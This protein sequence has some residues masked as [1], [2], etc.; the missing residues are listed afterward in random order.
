M[1]VIKKKYKDISYF[2]L[3]ECVRTDGKTEQRTLEKFKNELPEKYKKY[4]LPNVD[5][6]NLDYLNTIYHG[7]SFELMEQFKKQGLKVNLIL[8]DPPYNIAQ[9]S[10][11]T[12]QGNDIVSNHKAWGNEYEDNKPDAEAKEWLKRL[13]NYCFDILDDEGSCVI[14]FDRAKPHL[15]EEFHKLF[16]YRNSI[17][18]IKSNPIPHIRKTNYRSTF[19]QCFWFTKSDNYFL[20]FVSQ[21]DM[22]NVFHG[23]VG[24]NKKTTH[25]NEKYIWMIEPLIKRHSRKDDIVFDPFAGSGVVA[26]I[27]KR[28][29]RKYILCDQNKKYLI[30]AKNRL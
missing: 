4:Y 13:A 6:G 19:E 15:L 3:C 25:P 22:C 26:E 28:Y 17:V 16:C 7:D 14:F 23:S 5:A 20:N 2:Y 11:L 30:Q 1:Y 21:K 24:G 18:F 8:T 10:K 27:C 29:K 12:I 9:A